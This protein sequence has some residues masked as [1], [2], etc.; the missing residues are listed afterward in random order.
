M[1]GDIV[2]DNDIVDRGVGAHRITERTPIFDQHATVDNLKQHRG[3]Y[4]VNVT[5]G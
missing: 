1:I 3:L 2:A 4:D 5:Y